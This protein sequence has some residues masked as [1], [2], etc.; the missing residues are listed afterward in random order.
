MSGISQT[1]M[2]LLHPPPIVIMIKIITI[3]PIIIIIEHCM[4]I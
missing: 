4:R 2:F 1:H 3:K